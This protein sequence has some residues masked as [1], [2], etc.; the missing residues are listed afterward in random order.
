MSSDSAG[1]IPDGLREKIVAV[2]LRA[3]LALVL[4]PMLSPRVPLKLQRRWLHLLALL[5]RPARG[6]EVQQVI[7]AGLAAEWVKPAGDASRTAILYLHGGGFCVGSATTHRALT[8]RLARASGLTTFVPEYRLAPEFPYPAAIEDATTAYQLLAETGPVVLAGDSAGAFLALF[9]AV[10]ARDRGMRHPTSL[11]LFSPWVDLLNIPDDVPGELT[12]SAAFLRAS[13]RHFGAAAFPTQGSLAGLPPTL[14]Q[15][16][17][18]ELLLR[19]AVRLHEVMQNAGVAVRCEI[20]PQRW[21]A[22]QLHA[23][24]LPSA[25]AALA[26]AAQFALQHLA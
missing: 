4:K 10:A 6:I 15:A 25:D 23:G 19:D 22:F 24:I 2:S 9:V 16:G 13:A 11:L 8:T 7:T 18:E 14:I 12:T 1:L 20:V 17:G 3:A 5:Q 21:H 26:R